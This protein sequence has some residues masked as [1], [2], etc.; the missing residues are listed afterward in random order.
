MHG[1]TEIRYGGNSAA[2]GLLIFGR[3]DME[4]RRKRKGEVGQIAEAV[5]Q[6]RDMFGC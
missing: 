2:D 6:G 4:S 3:R 5:A 1:S